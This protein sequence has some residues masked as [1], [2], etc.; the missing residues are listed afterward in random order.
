MLDRTGMLLACAQNCRPDPAIRI[1]ITSDD[2]DDH[3]SSGHARCIQ[4]NLIYTRLNPLLNYP[5]RTL[6]YEL[7]PEDFSGDGDAAWQGRFPLPDPGEVLTVSLKWQ[8]GHYD[9][10]HIARMKAVLFGWSCGWESISLSAW[11]TV[12]RVTVDE[13]RHI[14]VSGF[15]GKL[16][17]K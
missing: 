13:W 14:T 17:S 6:L 1:W 15:S 11:R 9:I 2:E 4:C 12:A 7:W 10:R 5:E 16:K 8:D 3:P